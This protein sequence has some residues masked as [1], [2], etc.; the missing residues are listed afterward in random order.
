MNRV[1][2]E[3]FI[4]DFEWFFPRVDSRIECTFATVTARGLRSA[5]PRRHLLRF[6]IGL[7]ATWGSAISIRQRSVTLKSGSLVEGGEGSRQGKRPAR[8]DEALQEP[9]LLDSASEE[10]E[11]VVE[12][13]IEGFE[14]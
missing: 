14:V 5:V 3:S 12:S 13:V 10:L 1:A 9:L 11:R 2:A 4:H 6:F 8:R 7:S